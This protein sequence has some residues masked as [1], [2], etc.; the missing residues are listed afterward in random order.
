MVPASTTYQLS[1]LKWL[2]D[3]QVHRKKRFR[4]NLSLKPTQMKKFQNKMFAGWRRNPFFDDQEQC[5]PTSHYSIIIRLTRV[6]HFILNILCT[7]CTTWRG[8][9][10]PEHICVRMS[11]ENEVHASTDTH[12]MHMYTFVSG[13]RCIDNLGRGWRW[14]KIGFWYGTV[15]IISIL[16]EG[17]TESCFS[18]MSGRENVNQTPLTPIDFNLSGKRC[19]FMCRT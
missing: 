11:A 15:I 12:L 6:Q 19:T 13:K 17:K 3:S 9:W 1:C 14:E 16:V 4:R 10:P 8:C 2:T 7:F 5:D 18:L